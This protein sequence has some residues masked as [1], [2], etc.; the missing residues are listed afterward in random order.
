MDKVVADTNIYISSI[1]FGG[2]PEKLLKMA[3]AGTI[4]LFISSS[5]LH[6]ITGVLRRK[7]DWNSYQISKAESYIRFISFSVV[8]S[9]RIAII[10][11]D[12]TDNRVLE[13][14]VEAA[15]SHIVTGDTRHL[16]P[17]EEFRG[18]KILTVAAFFSNY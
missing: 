14:A 18:I 10:E 8:P 9:E 15:A 13:C 7:F 2:K 16:L 17:L 3:E 6:E 5:I 12:Y 11:K 4:Q 1:L